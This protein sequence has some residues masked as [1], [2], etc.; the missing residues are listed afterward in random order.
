MPCTSDYP[1]NDG[2]GVISNMISFKYEQIVKACT[3][4]IG[5]QGYL[6]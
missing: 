6:V 5:W 1:E 4:N 3:E 2:C